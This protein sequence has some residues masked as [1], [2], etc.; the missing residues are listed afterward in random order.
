[1]RPKSRYF[2]KL[3]KEMCTSD[4]CVTSDGRV[5]DTYNINSPEDMGNVA[6]LMQSTTILDNSKKNKEIYQDDIVKRTSLILGGQDV[7][8]VVKMLEGQW[9]V[10]NGNNAIPLWTECDENIVLGNIWENPELL[11]EKNE[12]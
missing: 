3:T 8:G 4:F 2:N 5:I 6:I 11:E 9:V 12:L 10:D 7:V 1:M